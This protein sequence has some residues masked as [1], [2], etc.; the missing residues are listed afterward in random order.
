[1]L[2]QQKFMLN[3][4]ITLAVFFAICSCQDKQEE[5]YPLVP[6]VT[7]GNIAFTGATDIYK[8][9]TLTLTLS[10]TD[11][12]A[13]IGL[14][15]SYKKYP[16]QY[17][18]YYSKKNGAQVSSDKFDL[19]Q[20]LVTDLITYAD[21]VNPPFDTLPSLNPGCNYH[22]VSI[23]GSAT[24]YLYFTPNEDYYN[25]FIDF[26]VK[27]TDGTFS[28]YINSSFCFSNINGRIPFTNLPTKPGDPIEI[29]MQSSKRGTITFSM[30]SF[31]FKYLFGTQI[32]KLK[33]FIKDRALHQ[34][35]TIETNEF[36]MQ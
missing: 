17:G 5:N 36:Q 6:A 4:N 15:D 9:D 14:D 25:L 10:F 26:Y 20:V 35:N 12:D 30:L 21:H 27:K 23:S 34:S 13:D 22:P 16:Y 7:F 31:A 28:K 32:S 29:K 33:V 24:N 18:Y 1:M 11:G 8:P 19:G 3:K 2:T